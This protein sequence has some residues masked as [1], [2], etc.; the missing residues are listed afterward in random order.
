[1]KPSLP[2]WLFVFMIINNQAPMKIVVTDGYTLNPGDLSWT[3]IESLGHIDYFDRTSPDDVVERCKEATVIVTNKTPI[4][5]SVIDAAPQ[6]K[7]IAVT[8]TGYNIVDISA[9]RERS[10]VVCNVPGYGTDAVAQHTFALLLELSNQVGRHAA[11]VRSGDWSRSKDFCYS[12]QTIHELSGKTIGVVGYGAIGMKVAEIARAFGMKVL[13][14]S[15]SKRTTSDQWV[16]LDELFA[17]SDV[18]S[19]HCP[20]TKENTGMVNE[21][22]LRRM[23]PSAF[24]INTARG[25]LINENDLA[26]A[27]GEGWIAGAALDVLSKEPPESDHPLVP[28]TNCIITPH[29][30][31]ISYEGRVRI[32]KTTAENIKAAL[33]GR[34]QHVV[35]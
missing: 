20:L 18:V 21:S 24:L 9:A 23:K 1:M 8:A 4:T 25:Q 15:R 13:Y 16:S 14:F 26:H 29:N 32:M 22:L 6:L 35:S 5:R 10:I 3:E 17:Q 34:P 28:L 27:L 12:F 7:L 31:W 19:L 33:S 30:A 11:S 2:G